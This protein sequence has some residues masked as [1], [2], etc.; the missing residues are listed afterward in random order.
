[1]PSSIPVSEMTSSV[2]SASSLFDHD[3][4]LVPVLHLQSLGGVLVLYSLP[5]K[6]E[7]TLVVGES[8]SR[9]VGVHQFLQLGA[10]LDFE[11]DFC[12]I[13]SLHLDVNME[14]V[15]VCGGGSLSCGCVCH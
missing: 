1:M 5:I 10:P 4:N 11:V 9:A 8:L 14:S 15:L 7:A 13:L 3:I 6:D 12:P 2:F